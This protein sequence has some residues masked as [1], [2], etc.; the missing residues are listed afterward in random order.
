[1]IP[2]FERAKTVHALD[3]APSL[4]GFFK[5]FI[6]KKTDHFILLKNEC[7]ADEYEELK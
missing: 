4:I 3:R 7:E 6:L 1:M 2:V 5:Y